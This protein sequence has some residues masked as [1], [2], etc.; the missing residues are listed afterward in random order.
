VNALGDSHKNYND[1]GELATELKI[2]V[3][4]GFMESMIDCV[5]RDIGFNKLSKLKKHYGRLDIEYE[6]ILKKEE[7]CSNY[8]EVCFQLC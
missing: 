5:G 4:P 6:S 2:K 3:E 8:Q 1:E 7:L